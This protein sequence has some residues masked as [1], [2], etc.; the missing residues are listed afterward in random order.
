MRKDKVLI[1]CGPTAT[2]KTDL[3]VRLCKKYSG[4]IVS[5]DSR[6]V[7][8][9]LDILTGKDIDKNSKL[10]CPFDQTVR[11]IHDDYN[12]KLN[13]SSCAVRVGYRL[14]EEIPIWL[15]DMVE[16]DYG[17]NVK[18]YKDVAMKVIS[19]INLHGKLPVVVGGTGF[20]IKS[21]LYPTET[22]SVY[23]DIKLRNQLDRLPLVRLQQRLVI[24][25]RNKWENMNYSDKQNPRRLIRA[26]EVAK[27]R[28]QLESKKDNGYLT[29]KSDVLILGLKASY[30]VLYERIDKR[31]EERFADGAIDEVEKILEKGYSWNLPSLTSTG[32]IHLKEIIQGTKHSSEALMAWKWDEH[33]FARRQMV[34]FKKLKNILWFDISRKSYMGEIDDTVGKWYNQN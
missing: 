32:A 11:R 23:P 31:V 15:T 26:I 21:L 20:Y 13:E 33:A 29:Q 25:D 1:I 3:A 22:F 7:Y 2:G 5:A 19:F 4:E 34:F 6:Q 14:K 10:K 18:E 12:S 17:F 9:G 27:S 24:E 8:R 30:P 16:P 28:A